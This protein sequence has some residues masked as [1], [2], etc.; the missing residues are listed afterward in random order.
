MAQTK[1]YLKLHFIVW[2]WGFTAILGLL[3][4]IPSVEIVFYRTLLAFIALGFLLYFRKRNFRL[5]RNEITK[6]L[7]TGLLIA[8]HWILFFAAA[9]VS[10]ASVC[11]AGMATCSLWTSFIEPVLNKRKINAV[12]VLLGVVVIIGL[13]VIFRFEF[14]H[15]LGLSMA[16]ASAFLSAL[17]T[18]I[19]GKFIKKHNPYMITF[20]EM[21]G[22]CLGTALFFPVYMMYFSGGELNLSPTMVDWGW[23][24]VLAVICTVYAYSVSVDLMKQLSAFV[25]NLTVNLEPVYGIILAV[26]IFG[27]KEQM[28]PGFYL[29]TLIILS[30]VLTYPLINRYKRRR[31][32]QVDHLR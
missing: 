14:D 26:I 11:L 8:A 22:A 3:I 32:M 4:T 13:Y 25:I 5:G 15:A 21:I 18:V 12:E 30:A 28:A 19:N 6:I 7:A 9:R 27:E 1:D 29:G 16:V 20:Y 24:F 10:T 2:I 17:F 31:A 23:L